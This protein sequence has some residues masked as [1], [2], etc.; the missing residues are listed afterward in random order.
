MINCPK[1][2]S[3][4]LL[5]FHFSFDKTEDEQS[6]RIATEELA[7]EPTINVYAVDNE[8]YNAKYIGKI[9]KNGV[10]T[11]LNPSTSCA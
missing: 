11:E 4:I 10:A 9:L 7:P 2:L 1:A 8:S 5:L 3:I 6:K